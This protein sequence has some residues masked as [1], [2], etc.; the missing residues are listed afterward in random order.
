MDN[1]RVDEQK[2]VMEKYLDSGQCPFCTETQAKTLMPVL[3]DGFFWT[4]RENKWPYENTKLHLIIIAKEH[5]EKFSDI[6]NNAGAELIALCCRIEKRFQVESGGI[7][8]RFG[9]IRFNGA[10]VAH[11]H[12]HFIVPDPKKTKNKKDKIR[13]KIG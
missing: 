13:F 8:M 6:P 11:L 10:T 9:N 2:K 4:V 3:E 5:L 7:A 12:M 1:A